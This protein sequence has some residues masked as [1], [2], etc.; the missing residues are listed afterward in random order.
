MTGGEL[1]GSCG[2]GSDLPRVR[3]H[4]D[5]RRARLRVHHRRDDDGPRRR[6]RRSVVGVLGHPH[7]RAGR[8]RLDPPGSDGPTADP[9]R[10]HR[11]GSRGPERRRRLPASRCGRPDRCHRGLRGGGAAGISGLSPTTAR[12]VVAAARRRGRRVR[13]PGCP[14]AGPHRRLARCRF[15]GSST[16]VAGPTLLIGLLFLIA[17]WITTPDPTGGRRRVSS[18]Q[19]PAEEEPSGPSGTA[20]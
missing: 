4:G 14:A 9:H 11:R 1:D 19:R 10:R 15:P 7:G 2:R 18:G 20:R 12:R 16:A 5:L 13:H 8:R 6:H 3:R 17:G